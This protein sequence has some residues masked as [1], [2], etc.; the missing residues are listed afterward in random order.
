MRFMTSDLNDPEL[1][2]HPDE[3]QWLSLE[4]QAAN[5]KLQR[6][7]DISSLFRLFNGFYNDLTPQ[8]T[9]YLSG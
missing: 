8:T 2:D 3:I 9:S 6:Y 4:L 7:N 1:L 5:E